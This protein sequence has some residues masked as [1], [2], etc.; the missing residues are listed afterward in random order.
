MANAPT[1]ASGQLSTKSIGPNSTPV[2]YT[3]TWDLFPVPIKDVALIT[4]PTIT[5]D[6]FRNISANSTSFVVSSKA[7]AAFVALESTLPGR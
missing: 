1:N 3:S 6:N 5:W 2:T 7:V 4:Q